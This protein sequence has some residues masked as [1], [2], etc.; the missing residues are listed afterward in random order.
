MTSD[1]V[2]DGCGRRF[3]WQLFQ[4][5]IML[6]NVSQYVF[7]IPVGC[8]LMVAAIERHLLQES[9][10]YYVLLCKRNKWE[11]VFCILSRSYNTVQLQLEARLQHFVQNGHYFLKRVA[12]RDAEKPF[13]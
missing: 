3:C 6:L 11:D 12:A 4:A 2:I 13:A 10:G 7:V 9:Y 1:A 8:I 5:R